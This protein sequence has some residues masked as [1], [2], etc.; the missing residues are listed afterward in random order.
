MCDLWP[1]VPQCPHCDGPV[2]HCIGEDEE[3]MGVTGSL[4][5]LMCG[6]DAIRIG[7]TEAG[8]WDRLLIELKTRVEI[9]PPTT[10]GE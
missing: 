6:W 4:E 9:F 2:Q 5:C 1:E 10:E 8:V 7:H 3:E